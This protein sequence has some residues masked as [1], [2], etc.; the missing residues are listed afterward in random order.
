[1]GKYRSRGGLKNPSPKILG[2]CSTFSPLW[3]VD[4]LWLRLAVIGLLIATK[5]WP[6]LAVYVLAGIF[7]RMKMPE[8][9]E[10][11]KGKSSSKA[12]FSYSSSS[13][14]NEFTDT[15]SQTISKIKERFDRINSRI[16]NMEGVVTSKDYR[17]EQKLSK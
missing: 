14:K 6:A 15:R 5:F 13:T 12:D 3:K 10:G 11:Y 7:I 8:K 1:M 9:L 2:V 16:E 17:W 4:V